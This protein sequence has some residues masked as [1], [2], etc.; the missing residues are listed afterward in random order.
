MDVATLSSKEVIT[1]I[2]GTT[3][4]TISR[5]TVRHHTTRD[6][7]Y[8]T[9][10]RIIMVG[11]TGAETS[12]DTARTSNLTTSQLAINCTRTGTT[13]RVGPGNSR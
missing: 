3:A 5:I 2:T 9:P 8:I 13:T 11:I 10:D 7:P 6:R 1:D 12:S 4:S